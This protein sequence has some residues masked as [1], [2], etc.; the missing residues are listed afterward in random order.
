MKG[1]GKGKVRE[2]CKIRPA[3][4][5]GVEEQEREERL[6]KDWGAM[7]NW[8]YHFCWGRGEIGG[9]KQ[10]KDQEPC[11]IR[12]TVVQGKPPFLL[13]LLM[14]LSV[15][16]SKAIH[17]LFFPKEYSLRILSSCSIKNINKNTTGF[18]DRLILKAKESQVTSS[19]FNRDNGFHLTSSWRPAMTS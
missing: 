1:K 11:R 18:W 16:E 5:A 4:S 10:K 9:E 15:T 2:P 3:T 7:Q 17:F 6:R 14:L 12:C 19:T 13:L 8:A